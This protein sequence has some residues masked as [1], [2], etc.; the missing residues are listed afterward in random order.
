MECVSPNNCEW[1]KPSA[2]IAISATKY[3][4]EK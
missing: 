1:G 4:L 3:E 2:I